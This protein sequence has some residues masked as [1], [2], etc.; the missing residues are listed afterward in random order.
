MQ[1]C[2]L[3]LNH[4]KLLDQQGSWSNNNGSANEVFQAFIECFKGF[5]KVCGLEYFD[6][7]WISPVVDHM[8]ELLVAYAED[9]DEE[10]LQSIPH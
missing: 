3:F 8:T 2:I 9:A 10:T 6:G 7:K 1:W 5:E 4:S